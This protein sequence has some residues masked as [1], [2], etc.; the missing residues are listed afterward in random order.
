MPAQLFPQI[1]N[2]GQFQPAPN[3]FPPQPISNQGFPGAGQPSQPQGNFGPPAANNAALGIINQLLTTPRQPP[4]G[5]FTGTNQAQVGGG[6]A[7]VAS[8]STG[9]SI[10]LYKERGK[11][12]EWEF[13]FELQQGGLPGQ[14]QP[15]QNQNRPPGAPGQANPSPFGNTSP[16]GNSSPS[17]NSS[18]FGNSQ[19]NP[20]GAPT[21]PTAPPRP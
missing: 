17:G 19:G 8:T 4:A 20:F 5:I 6:I 2:P 3:T 12:N 21:P 16:F 15:G 14:Q 13:T 7:G 10:K 1:Q 9:P 18:P 11:Y